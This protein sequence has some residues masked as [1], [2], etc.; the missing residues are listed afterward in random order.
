SSVSI[1]SS[2]TRG[3]A[4]HPV[5]AGVT[6]I[7]FL[8]SLS[9]HITLRLFASLASFLGGTVAF[10]AFLR[11]V[12]VALYAYVKSE[13]GRLDNVDAHTDTAPGT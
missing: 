2:W 11:V 5:A 7:A 12:D 9:S 10:I 3:L 4:L 6:L 8:P 1:G 13:V